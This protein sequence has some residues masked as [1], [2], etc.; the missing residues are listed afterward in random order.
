M[1]DPI[2]PSSSTQSASPYSDPYAQKSGG[3]WTFS[4][5]NVDISGRPTPIDLLAK[6]P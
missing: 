5:L 1:S 2:R 3:R 4:V 6:S